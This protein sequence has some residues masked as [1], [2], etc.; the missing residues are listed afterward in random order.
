MNLDDRLREIIETR[1]LAGDVP[2]MTDGAIAQIHKA[3]ADEGCVF[4]PTVTQ[5]QDPR[6]KWV[7]VNGKRVM[8]GAEW[9]DRFL[10][11][12]GEPKTFVGYAYDD[13]GYEDDHVLEAAKK[14]AGLKE[15][16]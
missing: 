14:A 11:E 10:K 6:D 9:Y 7:E 4:V 13:T 15:N 16:Q 8:T 3:Y 1:L 12:L 2:Y 5:S